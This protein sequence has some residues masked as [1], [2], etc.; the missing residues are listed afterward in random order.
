MT[1]ISIRP[2]GDELQHRFVLSD[3]R[4]PLLRDLEDLFQRRRCKDDQTGVDCGTLGVEFKDKLGYCAKVG[5]AT[6]DC[7]EEVWMRC[8]AGGDD[9]ARCC[10]DG[11][12][13]GL[14]VGMGAFR[15]VGEHTCTRLSMTRP[16]RPESQP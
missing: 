9:G 13:E 8:S 11:C 6:T 12:L 1:Y 16:C 10:D 2:H 3:I 7:E 15:V 5:A 14:D 4:P